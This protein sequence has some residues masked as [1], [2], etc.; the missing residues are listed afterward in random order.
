MQKFKNKR[1]KRIYKV[2]Y[3]AEDE[4][5]YILQDVSVYQG[6]FEQEQDV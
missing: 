2:R 1:Q 6:L 5:K 4:I 3:L